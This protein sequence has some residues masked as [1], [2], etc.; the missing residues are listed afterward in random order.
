[1]DTRIFAAHNPM[2][3]GKFER[4]ASAYRIENKTAKLPF[5]RS[6]K[7]PIQNYTDAL[8]PK[9]AAQVIRLTRAFIEES[10]PTVL[11]VTHSMQQA[12]ELGNRTIMMHQGAIVDELNEGEKRRVGID[13]LLARFSALRKRE[14]LTDELREELLGAYR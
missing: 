14:Q 12:L 11:M 8:D 4:A 10:G 2:C 1:M 13:D 5:E 9:S 7:P 3:Q 6:F